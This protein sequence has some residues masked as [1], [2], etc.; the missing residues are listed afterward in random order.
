M[1]DLIRRE[2]GGKAQNFELIR[3]KEGVHV[4]RC[5]YEGR[6]AVVK[7]FGNDAD[8]R[9]IANYRLL[10]EIDVPAVKVLSLGERH[11]VM[12][13]IAFSDIWRLGAE[14]DMN[15]P[16]VLRALAGWYF[17]LHEGS[18]GRRELQNMWSENDELTASAVEVIREE[19]PGSEELC[20]F[21]SLHLEALKAMLRERENTLT[22]ND[23]YHTNLT[24]RKDR[25]AA[26]MF[27][28]NLMGRGYRYADFRNIASSV[29]EEAFEAFL[30][31]YGR[32][33]REKHGTEFAVNEAE[34]K[35]DE[36]LSPLLGLVSALRRERFPAWAEPM[37]KSAQDG[38]L[39]RLGKEIFER[40]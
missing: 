3:E 15:D 5:A 14:E 28:Y 4:Y 40:C 31:E 26:M 1:I 35:M 16:C 39:L 25:S 37:K 30:E 21:V 6:R 12:E 19:T 32:L 9:E 38:T 2:T 11:I 18:Q 20:G 29:S 10:G 34:K 23:F 8:R 17:A 24:V 13:D 36:F 33:H 7:Y 22:Y 27:D